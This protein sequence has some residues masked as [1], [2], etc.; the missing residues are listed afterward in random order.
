MSEAGAGGHGG[1]GED[2]IACDSGWGEPYSCGAGTYCRR[3]GN[4]HFIE[5]PPCSVP[6]SHAELEFEEYTCPCVEIPE[7]CDDSDVRPTCGDDGVVHAN[8]CEMRR[9][10]RDY[11]ALWEDVHC[12]AS[13]GGDWFLC[14]GIYCRT[15][16]E[17]CERQEEP[18]DGSTVE[19]S[20]VEDPCAS[21]GGCDCVYPPG[22]VGGAGGYGNVPAECCE[23][24]RAG[25]VRVTSPLSVECPER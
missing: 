24:L 12:P 13:H 15:G 10:R 21:G 3:R 18:D 17:I 5:R 22:G 16:V 1:A 11:P 9:Q 20:C 8:V 4:D 14:D 2:E 19:F 23:E 6:Y 7:E 25:A